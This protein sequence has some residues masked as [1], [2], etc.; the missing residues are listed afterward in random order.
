MIPSS[1]EFEMKKKEGTSI[2][3]FSRKAHRLNFGEE[4]SHLIEKHTDRLLKQFHSDS[5]EELLD[6]ALPTS[7]L[8]CNVDLSKC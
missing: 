4:N 5:T 2:Y 1:M 7:I 8:V 3:P 6:K